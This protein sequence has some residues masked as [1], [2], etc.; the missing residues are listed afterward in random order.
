MIRPS[1]HSPLALR[2]DGISPVHQRSRV[3]QRIDLLRRLVAADGMDAREAQGEA[4]VVALRGLDRV[5]A[6]SNTMLG[7]TRCLRRSV[8]SVWRLKCSVSSSISTSVRPE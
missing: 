2:M 6:I 1:I 7:S 5:E 8:E 4:G 3:L